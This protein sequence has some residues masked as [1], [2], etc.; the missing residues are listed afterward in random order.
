MRPAGALLHPRGSSTPWHSSQTKAL[1]AWRFGLPATPRL[2]CSRVRIFLHTF[3][4]AAR[5]GPHVTRGAT[6]P[7]PSSFPI[8]GASFE[9]SAGRIGF[10]DPALL[11]KVFGHTDTLTDW[12]TNSPAA[13]RFA[14]PT[15]PSGNLHSSEWTTSI[16]LHFDFE[17]EAICFEP[18][19]SRSLSFVFHLFR[20]VMFIEA[21]DVTHR[22]RGQNRNEGLSKNF[23]VF[24]TEIFFDPNFFILT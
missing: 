7:P 12:P 2:G 18:L 14:H 24:Y 10:A 8:S 15:R 4:V 19:V 6:W 9:T 23:Q 3:Y 17:L 20:L 5:G 16:L 13:F 11:T 22:R 1:L 21:G